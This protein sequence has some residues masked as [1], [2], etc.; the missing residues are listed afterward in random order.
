MEISKKLIVVTGAGSGIGRATARHFA[1]AGGKVAICDLDGQR[2]EAL[3]TELG[4]SVVLARAV[5][6][7]DRHQMESFCA[8]VLAIATPDI[9]V[10]NAGV[11]LS[12]TFLETTIEDWDW[13]LNINLR[14]VMLGCHYLA[15][16][17]VAARR[18]HIVNISSVFGHW[19]GPTLSAYVASKFA[20]LG[21]SQ[22]LRTELAAFG[23]G[24][25]AICP[26]MINTA[27]IEGG[28]FVGGSEN[29]KRRWMDRFRKQGAPP[30][31]V[32]E[33]IWSAVER[34][35]AIRPVGN[36][37]WALWALTR[38]VPALRDKLAARLIR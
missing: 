35:Q 11:S 1:L 17:M 8:A 21:F 36:D 25:S 24:V 38:T 13:L 9:V 37:G 26:G 20:V 12:A 5:D 3:A 33:A 22:S 29:R 6:V 2:V 34:N 15:P 32:A 16:A 23:V 14:G 10:N 30:E 4:S 31:R 28:R 27:I 18:G 7:S 19:G